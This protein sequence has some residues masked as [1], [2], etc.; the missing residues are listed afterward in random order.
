[1]KILVSPGSDQ[2]LLP[3]YCNIAL[4]SLHKLI[5]IVNLYCSVTIAMS[6]NSQPLAYQLLD[7][8]AFVLDGFTC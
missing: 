2:F 1:M 4:A 3:Y 5:I 8:N 7:A 6:E